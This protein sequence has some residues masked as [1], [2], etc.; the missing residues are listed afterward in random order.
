MSGSEY[1]GA[2]RTLA[3]MVLEQLDNLSVR[4]SIIE[5]DLKM[6]ADE[7]DAPHAQSALHWLRTAELSLKGVRRDVETHIRTERKPAA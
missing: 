4:T 2:E 5:H 6:I 7:P 1:G 3:E